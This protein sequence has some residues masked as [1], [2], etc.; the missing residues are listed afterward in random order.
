M[1]SRLSM[2][3]VM[4]PIVMDTYEPEVERDPKNKKK[5]TPKPK[6]PQLVPKNQQTLFGFMKKS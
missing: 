1:S 2:E 5:T 4:R 3:R 6:P